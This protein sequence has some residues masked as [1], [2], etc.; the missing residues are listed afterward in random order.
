MNFEGYQGLKNL[1]QILNLIPYS[2]EVIYVILWEFYAA[3][4]VSLLQSQFMLNLSLYHTNIDS[5]DFCM[6]NAKKCFN[7][8]I[9]KKYLKKTLLKMKKSKITS[10]KIMKMKKKNQLIQET[11]QVLLIHQIR[12]LR[13]LGYFKLNLHYLLLDLL[14]QIKKTNKDSF[15]DKYHHLKQLTYLKAKILE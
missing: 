14:H 8:K 6:I 12:Y 5:N 15:Q 3:A 9:T 4:V 13:L 7:M 1:I 2:I 11:F 10:K